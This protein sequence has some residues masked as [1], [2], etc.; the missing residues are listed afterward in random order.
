[1]GLYKTLGFENAFSIDWDMTPEY[2]FG[3]FES[4]GGKERI[5]NKSERIYYFFIDNWGKSPKLYLMERGIKHAKLLAEIEAPSEMVQYCVKQQGK[6]IFD[7]NFAINHQI[8]KWLITNVLETDDPSKVTIIK[9]QETKEFMATGLPKSSDPLPSLPHITLPGTY[10]E[11]SEN[12]IKLLIQQY[13][14]LDL[15]YNSDGNFDNY[16]V[17]NEDNLTVTDKITGL[18]WQRGGLDIMSHRMMGREIDKTNKNNF[19]GYADWRLPSIAEALSLM[20]K[21]L[22]EFGIHLHPYFSAS[23]PFIF[24]NATRRTGGYWF[25]DFKQGRTFWAS[26]TIPGAF[27]RLCRNET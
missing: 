26:G 16:L 12:E 13:N 22:N 18:M 20:T 15:N 4:W 7:K 14:L 2:T 1:M 23:I 8:K 6:A 25:V 9:Q 19:A 17:D 10:E 27:G 24:A 3:T 21:D 5:R 11:M